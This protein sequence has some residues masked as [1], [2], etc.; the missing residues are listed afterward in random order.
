MRLRYKICMMSKQSNVFLSWLLVVRAKGR[1][2]GGK[3]LG[4]H[5]GA[6]ALLFYCKQVGMYH[7]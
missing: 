3:Q 5:M 4:K 6:V 7:N 1:E 2:K